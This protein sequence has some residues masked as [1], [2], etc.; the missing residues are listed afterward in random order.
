MTGL[1]TAPGVKHGADRAENR[2]A[3]ERE[4]RLMSVR[5]VHLAKLLIS[6]R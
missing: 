2:L 4:N 5:P 3:S 1:S 6:G